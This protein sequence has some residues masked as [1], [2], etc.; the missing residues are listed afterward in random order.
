MKLADAGTFLG[1][2]LIAG[3][4]YGLIFGVLP[5]IVALV[6]LVVLFI[7]AIVYNDP[8]GPLWLPMYLVGCFLY[9][10]SVLV[11]GLFLF[12]FSAIIQAVRKKLRTPW[13][14]PPFALPLL[15]LSI[16]WVTDSAHPAIWTVIIA[17]P[18]VV[19]WLSLISAESISK[20]IQKMTADKNKAQQAGP[21]YPPQGVGSADP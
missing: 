14:V 18:F 4:V 15:L 5:L 7:L 21:A 19:Y 10:L 17:L 13:W 11:C 1:S 16:L 8:G 9:A 20:R 12:G 3:I 6:G 2:H